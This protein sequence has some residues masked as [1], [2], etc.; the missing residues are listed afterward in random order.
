M[1]K[2]VYFVSYSFP[3]GKGNIEITQDMEMTELEHIR[4]VERIINDMGKIS[5]A[6]VNNYKLLRTV[7]S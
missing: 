7:D 4:G 5:D 3:T 2:Y 1:T 6:V